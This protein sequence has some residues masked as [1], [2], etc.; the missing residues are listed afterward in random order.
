MLRDRS[1]DV[2][3]PDDNAIFPSLSEGR[4]RGG[5][6]SLPVEQDACSR[7]CCMRGRRNA[8]RRTGAE[9]YKRSRGE[10][11]DGGVR[12]RYPRDEGDKG[13]VAA[14]KEHHSRATGGESWGRES[15]KKERKKVITR[16]ET[17]SSRAT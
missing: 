11:D 13:G 5:A 7:S 3:G 14:E 9:G 15:R 2:S 17:G 1:F 8:R 4:G 6:G 12:A 10:R 16:G